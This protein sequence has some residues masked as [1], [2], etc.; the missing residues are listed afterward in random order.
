MRWRPLFAALA[1]LLLPGCVLV[2]VTV[3]AYDAQC[4]TAVRQMTLQ[5]V[6]LAAIQG[7][8]N[9]GCVALLAVAGAT[10]AASAVVS[11]SIVIVGNAVYWLERQG[12]CGGEP[13]PPA[14]A[15]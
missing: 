2:P 7:C 14:A 3:Q 11:G 9:T 1:L 5:P 15:L 12:T 10:A 8:S 4:R 6:Q 13:V